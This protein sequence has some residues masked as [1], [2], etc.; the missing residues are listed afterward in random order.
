MKLSA[1]CFDRPSLGCLNI[2]QQKAWHAPEASASANQ[3]RLQDMQQRC[4]DIISI[5]RCSRKM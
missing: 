5:L 1:S 3:A 2:I 4:K